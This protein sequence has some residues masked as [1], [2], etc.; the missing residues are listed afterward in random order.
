MAKEHS[1][2]SIGVFR[3]LVKTGCIRPHDRSGCDLPPPVGDAAEEGRAG[4]AHRRLRQPGRAGPAVPGCGPAGWALTSSWTSLRSRRRRGTR[5]GAGT[6]PSSRSFSS[7]S[8][9]DASRA[10][11]PT[12]PTASAE[13]G[14]RDGRPCWR[15]SSTAGRR[16][17][18]TAPGGAHRRSAAIDRHWTGTAAGSSVVRRLAGL[19]TDR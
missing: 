6:G 5:S 16:R 9:P 19:D 10:S 8:V 2:A 4:G 3:V 18:G 1:R 7:T 15:P 17:G 12:R 11:S 13:V 14:D